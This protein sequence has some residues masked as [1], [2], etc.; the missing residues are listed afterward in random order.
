MFKITT[1]KPPRRQDAK[2]TRKKAWPHGVP[3]E[4]RA[5]WLFHIFILASWSLGGFLI[6]IGLPGYAS[7]QSNGRNGEG[8]RTLNLNQISTGSWPEVTLNMTLQGPDGKAVPDV[9]ANQFEV[10]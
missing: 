7:A 10:H 5:A 1:K 2:M 3:G 6:L 4:R 8:P 9:Q